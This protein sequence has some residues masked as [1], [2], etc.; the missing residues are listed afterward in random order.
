MIDDEPVEVL[1]NPA[2]RVARK[3]SRLLYASVE[4]DDSRR[5]GRANGFTDGNL[6]R[7]PTRRLLI[8]FDERDAVVHREAVHFRRI[9]DS[10]DDAV[11]ADDAERYGVRKSLRIGPRNR[12]VAIFSFDD[13]K[14]L[15]DGEFDV[16]LR[17]RQPVSVAAR[18]EPTTAPS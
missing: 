7:H 18:S 14:E 1:S 9:D 8:A 2:R 3:K 10:H 6:G 4:G 12:A 17:L 15:P 5:A 13:V 11:V 16:E